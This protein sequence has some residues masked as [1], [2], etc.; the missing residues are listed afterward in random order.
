MSIRVL[1]VED[2]P[3]IARSLKRMIEGHHNS[4]A[5]VSMAMNGREA[6]GF[7][8]REQ[9]DVVFTDIRMPLMDGIELMSHLNITNPDILKVAISGH[10]EFEYARKAIQHRAFDYLLKPIAKSDLSVVLENISDLTFGKRI[11]DKKRHLYE[12]LNRNKPLEQPGLWWHPFYSV[13]IVCAGPYPLIPDDSMSPAGEFWNERPVLDVL[14]PLLAETEECW[15]FDGKTNA[16]KVIVLGLHDRTRVDVFEQYYGLLLLQEGL[17]VTMMTSPILQQVGDLGQIC[18]E[19][20]SALYQQTVLAHSQ[21]LVCNWIDFKAKQD[22]HS[23]I[24]ELPDRANIES[25]VLDIA[26]KNWRGVDLALRDLLS[27]FAECRI[28][29]IELMHVLSQMAN[30]LVSR[31]QRAYSITDLDMDI[32]EAV[33]NAIHYDNL[34]ENLLSIFDSLSEGKKT[35][36]IP[37]VVMEVELFIS[38]HYTETITNE[39]LAKKFGFVPSYI[40]KLFRTYKGMSPSQYLTNTRI[41]RAK[42]FMQK[43]PGL[44]MKEISELVGFN[45]PLY[46]S[47]VFQK[48]TG[49][50]PTDY[51]SK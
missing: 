49:T 7:L 35:E 3:P 18:P 13:A 33:T 9:V 23:G 24:L 34:R 28:P 16:E 51:K 8:E 37:R 12:L 14:L 26:R 44:M 11:E 17:F 10:Q 27:T 48:Q 39:T 29:Q 43:Q 47:R 19:L 21:F 32:R 36:E 5:V 45:D 50:R 25:I 6:V 40:S 1:I 15:V 38:R 4:F 46:F 30:Q 31:M 2:E 41:E 20:R 22:V 42:E